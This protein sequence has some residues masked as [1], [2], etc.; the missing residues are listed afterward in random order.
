M[1]A[2][3]SQQACDAAASQGPRDVVYV[4]ASMITGGTQ[5]HLL[6]VFRF[7][8]RAR[9]RPR[10]FCLRD[11]GDLVSTALSLG[12]EVQTFGMKASLRSPGDVA[13]IARLVVALRSVRPAIVHSY[14]LRGNFF[15]ALSARLA[16]GSVVVTSKRGLHEPRGAPERFAVAVSNRLSDVITGNSPAVLDFTRANEP[17]ASRALEM[18]PSGIDTD[19]FDPATAVSLRVELELADAPVVGTAITWRPRKGF[20]LLFEAFAKVRSSSPSARLLIAGEAEWADDPKKL[21]DALGILDAI[22]LLGKRDDMPRVLATLDV[23]VLPSESEGM[24][25][26]LLEAMAMARPVVATA[27]GGNTTVVTEGRD[28]YLVSYPD[29]E[30]LAART[31]ALL[32]APADRVTIGRSARERVIA[33]FSARRMVK[34]MQEL[35]DRLLDD[36]RPRGDVERDRGR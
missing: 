13:G 24:S 3:V 32:A 15:G 25:N 11:G 16:R 4:I 33:A 36:D 34:Q 8:D 12:V 19:R 21:A 28:G 22:V 20:R 17:L 31:L 2:R 7:L 9:Y 23:F 26:A 14:L 6:Q 10:L 35:Y 30:A 27:V 29:S 5:T 1:R 18:I